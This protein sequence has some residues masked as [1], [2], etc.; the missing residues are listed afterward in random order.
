[1]TSSGESLLEVRRE[2]AACVIT[3]RREAKLN[4][5]SSALEGELLRALESGDVTESACVVLTGGPSVFSA[6]AD[7]TE[8]RDLDPAAILA[9][10]RATGD[11]YERVAALEQP[12]IS[13]IAGYALGGGLELALATDLRIADETAVFGFPEVA[14]GIAASSGGT[15][16]LARLV[17]PSLAKELLLVRER[18][19]AREALAVGLVNEVVAAGTALERA[20]ELAARIANLPRLAVAV[21]KRAVDLMPEASREAGVLIE[22]L[23]YGMLAQTDDAKEATDAFAAKRP[24]RFKGR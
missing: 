11:V 10:Y 8:L 1:M 24:P 19:T 14:L 15:V 7:I 20:L 9:Y 4:A 23:A 16:R 17:G 12:T 2:G 21:T 3:L 22:R 5:L 6:G 13:A 18:L